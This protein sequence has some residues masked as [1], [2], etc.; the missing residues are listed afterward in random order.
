MKK[1]Y[2]L[3]IDEKLLYKISYIAE[4]EHRTTP[5]QIQLALDKYIKHFELDNGE[6][7]YKQE[8]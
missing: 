4:K 6:I 8:Q 2:N 5:Q 7:Q 1:P 3:R